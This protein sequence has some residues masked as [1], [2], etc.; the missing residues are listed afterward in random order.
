MNHS[1]QNYLEWRFRVNNHTK[2]LKYSQQWIA[3]L[4]ISQLQ[5]FEKEMLNLVNKG[6]YKLSSSR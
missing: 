3:A 5:Y 1:L 4:Q 2:Y 6:I